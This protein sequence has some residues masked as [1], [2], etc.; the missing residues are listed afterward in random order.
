MPGPHRTVPILHGLLVLVLG[1]CLFLPG[2][3]NHALWNPDEPRYA[4][5]ARE[6]RAGG[7]YLVPHLNGDVYSQKPPLIFWA[8]DAAAW[9]TGELDEVSVRLPSAL[10]GMATLL[11]VLLLGWR[12]MG[13]GAAWLSVLVLATCWK[14]PLQARTGQIDMLLVFLVTLGIYFWTRAEWEERGGF[15]LLFF[16]AAGLATLAKG[17]VGLLP[18]LLSIL[19]FLIVTRSPGGLR[20]LRPVRGLI[21]WAAVVSA[22]LIPAGLHGGPAYL[23]QILFRQNVTRYMHPWGHQQPFYYFLPVVLADFFPWSFLLPAAAWSAL[24]GSGGK[25]RRAPLFMVCWVVVTLL[26]FSVSGGKRTV[27]ILTMY[28]G[29]ALLLGCGLDRLASQKGRRSRGLALS[30]LLV[31]GLAGAAA[32]LL[33]VLAAG[34]SFLRPL[35]PDYLRDVSLVLAGLSLAA[36]G[37]AWLAWKGRV[38]RAAVLM[39]IGA[40]AAALAASLWLLPPFDHL[41]SARPLARQFL[42]RSAKTDSYAMYPRLEPPFLFYIRRPAEILKTEEQLRRFARRPG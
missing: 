32:G 11:V 39:A 17:P 3:G 28:P 36:A 7:E 6:M 34:R 30:L 26:F 1:G 24:S 38:R 31:S 10:S 27:Y 20:R 29:M 35:P 19:A 42:S 2:L 33:P 23:Q 15:S 13:P 4:E 41:K 25:Q 9:F 8:M 22:W 40:G 37:S 16:A 18:P 21:L 5:V 14:I 12:L